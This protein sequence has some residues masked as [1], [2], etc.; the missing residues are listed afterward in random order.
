MTS[1]T[2]QTKTT[3]ALLALALT[4]ALVLV[5]TPGSRANQNQPPTKNDS[6]IS[7]PLNMR[8]GNDA[9]ALID[10]VNQTITIYRYD[11]DRTLKLLA[12]RSYRYDGLLKE[13]NTA[14]PRP[15]EVR[16]LLFDSPGP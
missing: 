6:I 2:G 13:Y 7:F 15:E 12:A 4:I 5:L 10:T 14:E 3:L 9:F 8:D 16:K 11:T 1:P